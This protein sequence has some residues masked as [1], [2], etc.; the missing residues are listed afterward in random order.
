MQWSTQ[1]EEDYPHEDTLLLE[2]PSLIGQMHQSN[3]EALSTSN[4][5]N[6]MSPTSV[7]QTD[8][9]IL[10]SVSED[11]LII[12]DISNTRQSSRNDATDTTGNQFYTPAST[13]YTIDDP[14]TSMS[15]VEEL[16]A[17]LLSWKQEH[18]LH[19][20]VSKLLFK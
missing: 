1:Y 10:P 20:L 4:D 8:N 17:L 19:I 15:E 5:S 3:N 13:S 14:T 11:P 9:M 16:Q 6:A 12:E 7:D 2:M 18:L